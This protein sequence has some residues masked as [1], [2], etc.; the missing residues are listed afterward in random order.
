MKH[1]LQELIGPPRF[2]NGLPGTVLLSVRKKGSDAHLTLI[3]YIPVR[4]ALAVDIIDEP[5][6]FAGMTLEMQLAR[7]PGKATVYPGDEE[8]AID[9]SGDSVYRVMLPGDIRGR[10]LLSVE[11]AL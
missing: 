3:H 9:S 7:K 11:G 10:L 1:A 5:Q 8:L 4:K 6:R 2:G